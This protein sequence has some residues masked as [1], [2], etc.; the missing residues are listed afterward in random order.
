MKALIKELRT[1]VLATAALAVIVCCLYPLTVWGVAQLLFPHEAAGSLIIRQGRVIGS[2]LI[3]RNFTGPG[4]FHSRPS[5][6]GAGCD[7]AASG[8]SNLGPL[9]KKLI[10]AVESRAAAYRLENGLAPDALV[11]VDAVTAS[12][13]GLDPHI[14]P[15]NAVLQAPRIAKARGMRLEAVEKKIQEH[16]EGRDLAMLGEPRVNVLLLNISLSQGR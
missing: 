2:K 10:D 5:A 4:Y 15:A 14:S 8:G 12:A 1:A 16:T 6:A 13:S 11:P 9:S 3:G 7:T